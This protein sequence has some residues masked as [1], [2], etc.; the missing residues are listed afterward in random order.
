MGREAGGVASLCG[1]ASMRV[2]V[3]LRGVASMCVYAL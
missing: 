3:S 2:V 1:V